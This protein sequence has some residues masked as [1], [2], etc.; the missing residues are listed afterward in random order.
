VTRVET[1][2]R[3]FDAAVAEFAAYGIAGARIERIAANAA[4]N[5]A[6]IYHYFGNKEDLFAHVLRRYLSQLEENVEMHPDDP[7]G[8]VGEVFDYLATHQEIV[9]LSQHEGFHFALDDVPDLANRRTHYARKIAA[10]RSAQAA[11][12]IDP[13]LDPRFVVMTIMSITNWLFAAPHIAAMVVGQPLDAPLQASFRA[14]LI[15]TARR[16]LHAP[17]PTA[18]A[19][20][21]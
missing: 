6:L 17:A 1:T 20:S 8:Y 3:I 12:T 4:S 10:V 11:G 19:R 15:E 5:K 9:R 16:M 13:T 21:E 14:H 18:D 7:A 2:Q